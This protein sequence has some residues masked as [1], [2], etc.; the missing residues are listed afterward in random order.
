MHPVASFLHFSVWNS[1]PLFPRPFFPHSFFY[2][3][4]ITLFLWWE[5]RGIIIILSLYLTT[6]RV[7]EGL[8]ASSIVILSSSS[9]RQGLFF[10]F[11]HTH[12]LSLSP[13]LF[14]PLSFYFP[15]AVNMILQYEL[16]QRTLS[17][18]LSSSLLFRPFVYS[19]QP[20]SFFFRT[21]PD[22]KIQSQT[23]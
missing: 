9:F 22:E 2:V 4:L 11:V 12:S 20:W 7:C 15:S 1:F 18:S 14:P 6:A 5:E 3:G 23:R 16:P 13:S 10:P 17:L 19:A 21:R 8:H